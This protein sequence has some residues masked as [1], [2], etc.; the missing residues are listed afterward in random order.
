MG[1]FSSGKEEKVWKNETSPF[2]GG[3]EKWENI[4]RI[5]Q[6][7]GEKEKQGRKRKTMFGEGTAYKISSCSQI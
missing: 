6:Y 2:D 1:G 5:K 7:F 3:K 4:W